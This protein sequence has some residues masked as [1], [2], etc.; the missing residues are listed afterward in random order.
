MGSTCRGLLEMFGAPINCFATD[1]TLSVS[2]YDSSNDASQCNDLSSTSDVLTV[3]S[4]SE[5]Y[6]GSW[7][8]GV[9]A[10]TYIPAATIV[11]ATFAPFPPPFVLQTIMETEFGSLMGTLP[12]VFPGDCLTSQR[13]LMCS[14][15]FMEPYP[16]E[17]L[18]SM[19]GIVYLPSFPAKPLCE[20]YES[21]CA[22]TLLSM[23]PFLSMNCSAKTGSLESFPSKSQTIL[24]LD[25]GFGPIDLETPPN[26]LPNSTLALATECPRGFDAPEHPEYLGIGWIPYTNCAMV[27]PGYMYPPDQF[28]LFKSVFRAANI[29]STM[30]GLLQ[31]INLYVTNKTKRN[32]FI[33]IQL[34]CCFCFSLYESI[35]LTA[36]PYE[37]MLCTSRTSYFVPQHYEGETKEAKMLT[38]N[39]IAFG[40]LSA[41][42]EFL[43]FWV[44]FAVFV[45]LWLR[46]V[47]GI[48]DVKYYRR[49]YFWGG[50]AV[51]M[52]N[53]LMVVLYGHPSTPD[54]GF[55]IPCTWQSANADLV[56]YMRIVPHTIYFSIAI[57]L[58]VHVVYHC[59]VVSTRV[60]NGEKNPLLKLWSSY[61]ILFLFTMLM[62]VYYIPYVFWYGNY[63]NQVQNVKTVN[64]FIEWTLCTFSNFIRSENL[65]YL[66]TCGAHLKEPFPIA[67]ILLLS[68]LITT[69]N[70]ILFVITLNADAK[71][72]WLSVF[73]VLS[74][75]KTKVYMAVYKRHSFV[76]SDGSESPHKP[77]S[78][79]PRSSAVGS[80]HK[81]TFDIS[82]SSS[83]FG[84]ES[85][86]SKSLVGTLR[87]AIGKLF[88]S[89]H[90]RR[91]P[92][93]HP[94]DYLVETPAVFTLAK[95]LDKKHQR[96]EE[97]D[98]DATL[99]DGLHDDAQ[100]SEVSSS[101][102]GVGVTKS[103]EFTDLLDV[104]FARQGAATSGRGSAKMKQ[105]GSGIAQL[106]LSPVQSG[107]NTQQ[108]AAAEPEIEVAPVVGRSEEDPLIHQEASS[109]KT[110]DAGNQAS[111]IS[112]QSEQPRRYTGIQ[113]IGSDGDGHEIHDMHHRIL[114]P[115][116]VNPATETLATG[117]KH[118]TDKQRRRSSGLMNQKVDDLSLQTVQHTQDHDAELV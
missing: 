48:K 74:A 85:T 59:V 82:S 109:G 38:N 76:D 25:L 75:Q 9:A 114:L 117:E 63:V 30:L 41:L 34:L 99:V 57:L 79:N 78:K 112:E 24:S 4:S 108:E 83:S 49:F 86:S 40:T 51:T 35:Q 77:D 115:P 12:F 106:T 105:M 39:C 33:T 90:V 7:C 80:P 118:F 107:C 13:K 42:I 3:G 94:C 70:L 88:G 22:S 44:C 54:P 16:V 68:L 91:E 61:R 55:F 6:V 104:A 116:L 8:A 19:F 97:G 62:F 52:A 92:K 5:K 60:G 81:N 73:R 10:N 43:E 18:A 84:R 96:M 21:S 50:L 102:S 11:N 29:A 53:F 36:L 47:R 72:F 27:C 2:V 101:L 93:V 17:D 23:L 98:K 32:V 110:N 66:D 69:E 65:S 100:M 95:D 37:D 20:E 103:S 58:A 87:A 31:L 46:V 71:L 67:I 28:S 26:Y 14:S 64:S 113:L 56:Y 89:A 15:V 1:S 111:F 45:E